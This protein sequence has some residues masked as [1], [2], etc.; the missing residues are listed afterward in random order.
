M[1]RVAVCGVGQMGRTVIE[2]VEAAEDMQI[3]GTLSPRGNAS[4]HRSTSGTVYGAHADPAGLVAA[5]LAKVPK[6]KAR[7]VASVTGTDGDPQRYAAQVAT[8]REGLLRD[9]PPFLT[10]GSMITTDRKSVV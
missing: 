10:G 1:I 8:L 7:V 6:S 9:L 3:V 4:D 5:S 2:A